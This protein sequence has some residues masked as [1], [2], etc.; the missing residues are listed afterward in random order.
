M[1]YK[2][3]RMLSRTLTFLCLVTLGA[4]INSSD[5]DLEALTLTPEMAFPLASGDISILD[6]LS[7]E[8]SSY[9]KVDNDGL[10]YLSYSHTLPSDD[11]KRLFS[12]PD[13]NSNSIFDLPAGSLPLTSGD[14]PSGTINKLVDLNLNPEQLSEALLKSGSLNYNIT[15]AP[16]G[17]VSPSNLPLEVNF[18]LTDVV[19]KNTQQPLTLSAGIGTGS[20]SLQDYILKMDKNKFNI[21]LSL[22]LKKRTSSF[23]VAANTKLNVY[24]SF[25]GM[26]FSLI[27][28]FFGDQAVTLPPQT[29]DIS[30]FNSALNKSNISFVQPAIKMSVRNDYGVPCEITFAKLEG[31]KTG[32][33]LPLQINP[34]S[35][36]TL[37]FP[38][39]LGESATT[40]VAVNNTQSVINFSPSQLYFS[41][42]A[43]INKGLASGNNFLADTSKLVIKLDTEVP[44]YGKASNVVLSDT[45]AL[46]LNEIEASS[47][48][49]A[50]LKVSALNEMP[51]DANIQF[52]LMDSTFHVLDSIFTANQTYLVKAS[53][54]LSSGELDK[55]SL[56]DIKINLDPAKLNKLFTSSHIVIK[57]ILNTTKD[58][59]GNLLNVKFKASYKLKLSLGLLTKI[60]IKSE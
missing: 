51:L 2:L 3:I 1:P 34:S 7:S 24:L 32:S 29:A 31:K 38:S 19:N 12:L 6:L 5:Y 10:L 27:K 48:H 53:K 16:P 44:L 35:P 40:T 30:F 43:R 36:I 9:L 46:D 54:V 41:A 49:T 15:F 11:I 17:G 25:A 50:S 47:I 26:Q 56:N 8:D 42:S 45:I 59:N 23:F 14:T 4:C 58:S 37:S 22:V 28:G 20:H 13:N 60:E 21:S 55:G 18:M 39:L 57:S 52:Y 33:T